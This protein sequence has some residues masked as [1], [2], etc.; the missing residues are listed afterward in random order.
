MK[1]EDTCAE[2]GSSQFPSHPAAFGGIAYFPKHDKVDM[3]CRV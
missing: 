1:A 3:L 2:R